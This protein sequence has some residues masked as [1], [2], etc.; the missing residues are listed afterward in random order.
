V[1]LSV[2]ATGVRIHLEIDNFSDTNIVLTQNSDEIG[3]SRRKEKWEFI[4]QSLKIHCAL[5]QESFN[6]RQ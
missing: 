5:L 1:I 3:H 6:S 2:V 4:L